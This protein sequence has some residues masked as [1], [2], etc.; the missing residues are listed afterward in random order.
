MKT[1]ANIS[2]ESSQNKLLKK[3]GSGQ[4][5]NNLLLYMHQIAYREAVALTLLHPRL[6]RYSHC[7]AGIDRDTVVTLQ[8]PIILHS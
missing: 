8:L 3:E 4:K 2:F 7:G 5:Y 6:Q 1:V